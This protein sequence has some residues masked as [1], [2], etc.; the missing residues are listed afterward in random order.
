MTYFDA[1]GQVGAFHR[2]TLTGG[3]RYGDQVHGNNKIKGL[4]EELTVQAG[5]IG[6]FTKTT[7]VKG[8]ARRNSMKPAWVNKIL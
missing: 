7:W 4:M 2:R 8:H 3:N 5:L 6:T 1:L